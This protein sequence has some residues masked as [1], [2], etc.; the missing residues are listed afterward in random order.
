MEQFNRSFGMHL[1][2]AITGI[3]LMMILFV[4]QSLYLFLENDLNWPMIMTLALGFIFLLIN[5]WNIEIFD[6]SGYSL[7]FHRPKVQT[8]SLDVSWFKIGSMEIKAVETRFKG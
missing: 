4:F 1:T 2:S 3:T 7:G 8:T 6:Q 5:L